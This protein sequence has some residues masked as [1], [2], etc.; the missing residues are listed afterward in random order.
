MGFCDLAGGFCDHFL[1]DFFHHKKMGGRR[2]EANLG[3]FFFFAHIYFCW[4]VVFWFHPRFFFFSEV[5]VPPNSWR[6]KSLT[7][8]GCSLFEWFSL[9]IF[10]LHGMVNLPPPQATV[11]PNQEI[12]FF[13]IAGLIKGNQ[14]LSQARMEGRRCFW[15][16]WLTGWPVWPAIRVARFS[17]PQLPL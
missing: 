5:Q 4:M 13:F 12:M 7:F 3:F 8:S 16:G 17:V 9:G 10:G 14:W 6:L 1:I 11:S 15:G 2:F